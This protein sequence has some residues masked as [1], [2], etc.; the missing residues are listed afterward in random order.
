MRYVSTR[1]T[2]DVVDFEGARW[3]V[4]P[5][6]AGSTCRSPGPLLPR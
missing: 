5:G 6:T 4:S 3:P 1:G 2:A